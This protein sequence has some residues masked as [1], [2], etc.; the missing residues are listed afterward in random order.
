VRKHKHASL[1]RSERRKLTPPTSKSRQQQ[2][3]GS[4]LLASVSKH[5]EHPGLSPADKAAGHGQSQGALSSAFDALQQSAQN[6]L[7]RTRNSAGFGELTDELARQKELRKPARRRKISSP[8][9]TRRSSA[10]WRAARAL[11]PVWRGT[12]N[13]LAA[14]SH[15]R[16]TPQRARNPSRSTAAAS[17]RA[18]FRLG[19][20]LARCPA[21][22]S[23]HVTF[24]GRSTCPDPVGMLRLLARSSPSRTT[25]PVSWFGI[26]RR[27]FPAPF[28]F[29]V[30][31]PM[32]AS[33]YAQ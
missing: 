3:I 19:S 12:P 14:P 30:F 23:N 7:A 22:F 1:T 26:W 5:P 4:T 18:R 16:R 20:T 29:V 33:S 10:R 32:A 17:S 13:L 31:P 27:S 8:S 2:Q 25:M 21:H 9:P 6:R 24:V 11:R 28:S 15:S